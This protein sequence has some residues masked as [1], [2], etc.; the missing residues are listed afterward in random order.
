MV[1][2]RYVDVQVQRAVSGAAPVR[3]FTFRTS[4]M[5]D[6]D[7]MSAALGIAPP[8]QATHKVAILNTLRI[9]LSMLSSSLSCSNRL[10]S[11]TRMHFP[12]P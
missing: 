10:N 5:F 6:A 11:V 2:P 8:L 4:D 12:H 7:S 1:F 9:F 3:Q